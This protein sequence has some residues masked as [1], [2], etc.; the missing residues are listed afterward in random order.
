MSMT[1]EELSDLKSLICQAEELA[2]ALHKVQQAKDAA[3]K[4]LSTW[5]AMHTESANTERGR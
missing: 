5:L 3:D 2:L 1:K 4:R